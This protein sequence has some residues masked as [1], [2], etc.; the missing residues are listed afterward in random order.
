VTLSRPTG[1]C[2][3]LTTLSHMTSLNKQREN[4]MKTLKNLI[5]SSVVIAVSSTVVAQGMDPSMMQQ[6]P[7]GMTP[8][9]MQQQRMQN[10]MPMGGPGMMQMHQQNMPMMDPVMR[11]NMMQYRHGY[12]GNQDGMMN[13]QNMQGMMQMRQQ[14]MR[15]MEQRLDKIEA[16][17]TELLEIQKS[18]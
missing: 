9:Q 1:V 4:K 13:H 6:Y 17:L 5:L 18:K 12:M 10:G 14:H 2:D 7:G 11:K 16:M 3:I 15:Q 8:D